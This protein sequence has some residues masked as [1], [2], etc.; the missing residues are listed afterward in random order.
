MPNLK[1][2]EMPLVG[3]IAETGDHIKHIIFLISV[4][5]SLFYDLEND[6]FYEVAMVGN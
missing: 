1:L 3:T 6:S 5:V 2:V 4:M